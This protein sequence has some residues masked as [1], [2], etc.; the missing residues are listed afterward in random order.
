MRNNVQ[1]RLIVIGAVIAAVPFV[2]CSVLWGDQAITDVLQLCPLAHL[3]LEACL[4]VLWA[5]IVLGA[6][7]RWIAL[8]SSGR[9]SGISG[10]I[11]LTFALVLLFPVVS[12][13]DDLAQF[14]FIND[15][16]TSQS[17]AGDLKSDIQSCHSPAALGA[18]VALAA[19]LPS[20]SALR[21]ELIEVAHAPSALILGDNT[22][23]HSPP[24]C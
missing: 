24:S 20:F 6:F 12:A 14:D 19:A 15:V 5:S 8:R 17:I 10:F 13:N 23:N 16:K 21:I 11:S 4:N 2:I 18:P 22:G 3:T 9:R 7:V 1:D